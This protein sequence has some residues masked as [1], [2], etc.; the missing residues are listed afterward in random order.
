ME[1]H[2]KG[3]TMMINLKEEASTFGKTGHI[4]RE[5]LWWAACGGKEC[6]NHQKIAIKAN[7]IEI[8]SM[9]MVFIAGGMEKFMRG[10]LRMDIGP[11]KI[12]QK[13]QR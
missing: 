12:E 4:T 13:L 1:T 9:D 6:G 10:G 11:A 7:I 5:S 3:S 2:T 8:R